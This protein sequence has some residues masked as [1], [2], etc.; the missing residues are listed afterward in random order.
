MQF[1]IKNKPDYASLHIVL[2]TGDAVVTEAGAMM[3][4]SPGL[5]M[6][7]NMKGGL[8]A[9]AKRAVSGESVFLNTYTA[10]EEGQRLLEGDLR[11]H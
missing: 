6:E 10:T 5:K 1:E 9:A 8:L 4:M 11:K 2:G 7:T 3:G